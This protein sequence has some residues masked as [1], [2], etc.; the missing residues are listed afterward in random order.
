MP[1]ET[2]LEK[3]RQAGTHAVG[4]WLK[5]LKLPD[6]GNLQLE[7]PIALVPQPHPAQRLA[8]RLNKT[9]ATSAVSIGVAPECSHHVTSQYC[10]PAARRL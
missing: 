9:L 5:H 4:G 2:F 1:I 6:G 7:A 3:C 8:R 10:M